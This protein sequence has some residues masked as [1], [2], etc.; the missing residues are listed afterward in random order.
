MGTSLTFRRE[1]ERGARG[2]SHALRPGPQTVRDLPEHA[3]DVRVEIARGEES[4][5]RDERG[6][7]GRSHGPAL[8]LVILH[9]DERL[10]HRENIL[11]KRT[12]GW[13][14]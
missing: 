10:Q 1:R 4:K 9:D 3:R 7:R 8:P 5:E 11:Y 6:G 14:S 13:S 12:S 2:V